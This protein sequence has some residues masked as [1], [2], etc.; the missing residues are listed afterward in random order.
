MTEEENISNEFSNYCEEH[1]II[2][3]CTA[4]YTPQQNGVAERKN[5]TLVKMV[6]SMLIQAQLPFNLWGEALLA[7]CHVLNRIP[8]KKTKTSPSKY[9]KEENQT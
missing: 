6:N 7:A 1:G 2:H 8:S 4:P 3:Q 9:G 5:R